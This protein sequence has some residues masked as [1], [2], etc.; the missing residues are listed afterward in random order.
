MDKPN[1][2]YSYNGIL[3]S[4]KKTCPYGWKKSETE[5]FRVYENL[6]NAN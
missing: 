1:V 6:E 2:A 3:L 5:V 4:R